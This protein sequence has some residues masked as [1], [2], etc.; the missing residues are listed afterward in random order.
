MLI[1]SDTYLNGFEPQTGAQL[2]YLLI[3]RKDS[4]GFI[5]ILRGKYRQ[6]DYEY[7]SQQLRGMT[8]DE[9]Q[10]LLSLPFD[11]LW[12][13][14]WGPSIDGPNSYRHEREQSRLKLDA[15]RKGTPS[16]EELIQ[17]VQHS[18]PSP[19]WGFPKGRRES[20]ET[21]YACALREMWEET[22]LTERDVVPVKNM[23]TIRETFFGSNRIQ[24]CHKYYI[25]Y[26]PPGVND[27]VYDPTNEHMKREIGDIR[28][29]N[30]ET[31][32]GLIRHENV[33]K[34]EVLLRVSRLLRNYCPFQLGDIA[35]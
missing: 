14:L 22:G 26:V 20:H 7:V 16:L 4:L 23:E 32:I 2:E 30:L 10:R 19:E 25:L 6:N 18:W 15:L 8:H 3:Q 29:C 11:I 24:Y 34:R 28:W 5:D 21:E 1:H 35:R 31:A 12:E 17:T 27:P 13:Q 9:Q 33:E